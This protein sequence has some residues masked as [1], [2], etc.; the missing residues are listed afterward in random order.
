MEYRKRVDALVFFS[1]LSSDTLLLMHMGRVMSQ[2]MSEFL[3]QL[4]KEL[5]KETE[6]DAM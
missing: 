1:L 6:H 4:K 2:M 5:C 3:L